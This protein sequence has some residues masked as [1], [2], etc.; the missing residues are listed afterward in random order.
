MTVFIL[1]IRIAFGLLFTFMGV[2]HFVKPK[3]FN[4]FIPKP[5]PRLLINYVV[6]VIEI[7]IGIGLFLTSTVKIAASSFFILMLLFLPLH[8]WDLFRERPAIGSK[9]MAIIRLP[10]QFVFLFIAYLIYMNS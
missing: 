8:I 1:I 3:V 4:G 2:M 10:I 9:K 5:L 7:A 6:G